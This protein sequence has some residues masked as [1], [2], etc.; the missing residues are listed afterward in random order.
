MKIICEVKTMKDEK[1][2]EDELMTDEELDQVAGGTRQDFELV[3]RVLGKSSTWNTRDG[4]R[5]FLEKN[6]GVRCDH[7]NTGDRGSA[8]DAPAE[9]TVLKSVSALDSNG[10]IRQYNPGEKI[11]TDDVCLIIMNNRV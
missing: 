3:C 8:K 10:A 9:F 4:I 6:Y 1:I 7:W 11:G 5:N 2:L